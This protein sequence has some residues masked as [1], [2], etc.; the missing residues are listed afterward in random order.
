M[1]V[2]LLITLFTLL[3]G[4][5]GA[6]A[7]VY[8]GRAWKDDEFQWLGAFKSAVGFH[9]GGVGWLMFRSATVS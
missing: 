8:A 2:I 3:S 4:L 7:F 6:Q 5:G 9:F 1:E